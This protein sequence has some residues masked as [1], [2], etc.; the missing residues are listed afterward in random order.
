MLAWGLP[1]TFRHINIGNDKD[2]NGDDTNI[3][4]TA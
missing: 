1:E 3:F 2:D 4:L